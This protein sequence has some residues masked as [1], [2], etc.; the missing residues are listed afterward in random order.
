MKASPFPQFYN[1]GVSEEKKKINQDTKEEK[2]YALIK[3]GE[4]E[5]RKKISK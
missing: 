4:K 3:E 1:A 2:I 5:I